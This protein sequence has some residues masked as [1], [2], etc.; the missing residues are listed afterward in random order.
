MSRFHPAA[1]RFKDIVDSG[2]IG[3][4]KSI[5]AKLNIPKGIVGDDDIRYVFDLGGGALMDCGCTPLILT[6]YLA[7]LTRVLDRLHHQ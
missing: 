1:Q 6:S 7:V 3:A 5:E 2:E 4:I